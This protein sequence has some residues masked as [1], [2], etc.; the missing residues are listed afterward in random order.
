MS[1]AAFRA[2]TCA[3]TAYW[4]AECPA[5][6]LDSNGIAALARMNAGQWQTVKREAM[7]ALAALLPVL[8]A[9][10][11]QETA[12]RDKR[13]ATMRAKGMRGRAG[14]LHRL[15]AESERQAAKKLQD[16][17][18]PATLHQRPATAPPHTNPR[19]V[20]PPAQLAE[21]GRATL[22][23]QVQQNAGKMVARLRDE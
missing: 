1:G 23:K 14:V 7:P 11:A 20:L 2:V 6:I 17:I 8:A 18:D 21:I 16:T 19:A 12:A 9:S 10:Y 5:G 15:K 4:V 22:A 3:A 13:S